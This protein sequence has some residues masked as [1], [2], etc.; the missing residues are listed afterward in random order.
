MSDSKQPVILFPGFEDPEAFFAVASEM[1]ANGYPVLAVC[2]PNDTMA[3]EAARKAG[4]A[5]ICAEKENAL[6][7][8]LKHFMDNIKGRPGI[9]TVD[10]A[11]GYSAA[12]VLAVA[13]AMA[14]SP[15]RIVLAER[16]TN[17]NTRMLS[18]LERFA[19]KV[20]FL[21]V[22]GRRVHDA[23]AGLRGIPS[24]HVP[25][26]LALNGV[27]YRYEFNILLNL[28][29]LGVKAENVP[30][31]AVYAFSDSSGFRQRALDILRILFLPL[32]F[33]SASLVVW[34]VDYA[35]YIVSSRL[36]LPG[37]NFIALTA[38]RSAGAVTGY[39]LNRSVVFRRTNNTWNKELL[40]ALRFALLAAFNY[41]ASW[42]LL[43][44]LHNILGINDII[45]RMISDL[46][47]YVFS[48]TVQRE[49]VFHHKMSGENN[50]T[51]DN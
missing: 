44:L 33:V 39:L 22:H 47:L 7:A 34:A 37:H 8:G 1:H 24:R 3:T 35:I 23:W 41:G 29:H 30:V 15:D 6:R 32:K 5:V 4:F 19:A 18:R 20:I 48:Y 16:V 49:Y 26:L 21:A 14:A 42:G 17:S 11:E 13:G 10:I 46:L 36:L 28:Q 27:G 2:S 25:A 51:R 40:A 12:D 43:Y 50:Q 9:V 38:A 45:A 31:G